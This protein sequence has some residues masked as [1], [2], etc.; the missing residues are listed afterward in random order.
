M[1]Q[2][3][4]LSKLIS[5]KMVYQ[6]DQSGKI[7][8]TTHNTVLAFSNSKK[9]AILIKSKEKRLLQ[10]R[11]REAGKN[12]VFVYRLFALLIFLL[13]KNEKFSELIIDTE[14]PGRADLIKNYLLHDFGRIGRKIDPSSISFHQIGKNCE[15]HWHGYYVFKG[16]RKAELTITAKEV[17]EE[18]FH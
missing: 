17:L 4:E 3:V 2:K 12:Q 15:A 1:K 18:I 11:F 14:Y 5:R 6:I 10:K 7:E 8:Y 9:G 16:K 13:L